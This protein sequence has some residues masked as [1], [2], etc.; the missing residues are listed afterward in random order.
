[1]PSLKVVLGMIGSSW[2]FFG[3]MVLGIQVVYYPLAWICVGLIIY[4][5]GFIYETCSKIRKIRK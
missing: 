4:A 2:L 1:M 3:I 5:S